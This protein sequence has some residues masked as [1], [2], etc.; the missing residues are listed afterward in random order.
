MHYTQQNTDIPLLYYKKV[1]NFKDWFCKNGEVK[2]DF[3]L[4]HK[5]HKITRTILVYIIEDLSKESN[6]WYNLVYRVKITTLHCNFQM[7]N[8]VGLKII[9][10]PTKLFKPRK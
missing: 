9:D 1:D 10:K 6:I 3:K 5:D 8:Q 2:D 4:H 7:P